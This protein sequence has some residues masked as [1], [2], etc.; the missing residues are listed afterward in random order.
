MGGSAI[1]GEILAI[2][3]PDL[4]IYL[5]SDYR[6]PST[7]TTN[8]LVICVSWSGNTEETIAAYD[9][10]VERAC[11]VI[12]IS[13]GGILREKAVRQS[14]SVAAMPDENVP[15]RFAVGYMFGALAGILGISDFNVRNI[16]AEALEIKGRDIASEIDAKIPVIY[17]SYKWRYLAKFWKTLINE[18]AKIPAFWNYFPVLGHNEICQFADR[19]MR[20]TPILLRNLDDSPEAL[21]DIKATIAIL[22]NMEYNYTIIDISTGMSVLEQVLNNYILALWTSFYLAKNLGVDPIDTLLVEKFKS[23]KN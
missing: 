23:Y 3:R 5:N 9:D 14:I 1:P 17:G 2:I 22:D 13:K 7:A 18:N 8:D 16:N 15:A 12:V 10:A 6:L 21:K 20:L 19:H 4:N 11:P